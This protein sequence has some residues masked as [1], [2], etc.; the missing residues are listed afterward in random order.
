MTIKHFSVLIENHQK[1]TNF[2]VFD[3]LIFEEPLKLLIKEKS[4]LDTAKA[5]RKQIKKNTRVQISTSSIVSLSVSYGKNPI[6][7]ECLSPEQEKELFEAL[8]LSK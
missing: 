1:E 2:V 7:Y 3:G 6:H 4:I 5:I 8:H